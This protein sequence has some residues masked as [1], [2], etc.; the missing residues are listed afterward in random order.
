M[1]NIW[2]HDSIVRQV[3]RGEEVSSKRSVGGEHRVQGSG[4]TTQPNS[5]SPR[6]VW[7][8]GLRPS[9][10]WDDGVFLGRNISIPSFRTRRHRMRNL[11]Q[12]PDFDLHPSGNLLH[13]PKVPRKFLRSQV[14]RNAPRIDAVAWMNPGML[15]AGGNPGSSRKFGVSVVARRKRSLH[16][17]LSVVSLYN[18][19]HC[20]YDL[21]HA[22]CTDPR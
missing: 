16:G 2:L 4:T 21:Q 12:F 5:P 20:C 10:R 22:S 13:P 9:R 17:A 14:L 6:S 8:S 19:H 11:L 15:E 3:S 18:D 1:G 7:W